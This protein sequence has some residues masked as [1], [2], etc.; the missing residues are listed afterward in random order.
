MPMTDISEALPVQP[1]DL[2]STPPDDLSARDALLDAA[3][4]V[5]E[6]YQTPS[7]GLGEIA[8][9]AGVSADASSALFSSVDELLIEAALRNCR[10]D[11]GLDALAQ[12]GS[13]PTVSAYAHHFARRKSFYRAM[14]DGDVAAAL[15]GRMAELLAPFIAVQTRTLISTRNGVELLD[16]MILEVTIECFTV[17]NAWILESPAAE[18]AEGLYVRLE[19]IVIRR[20]EDARLRGA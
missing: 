19:E 8:A 12:T 13:A 4:G 6:R 14:R 17:T 11:L 15:D 2:G 18:G 3:V 5:V 1:L 7:V 16:E 9:A 20:I 10:D